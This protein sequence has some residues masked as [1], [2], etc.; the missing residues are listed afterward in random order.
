MID[1][2]FNQDIECVKCKNQ[3]NEPLFSYCNCG[4]NF[5]KT[6]EEEYFSSDSNFTSIHEVLSLLKDI[7]NYYGFEILK[8][9][10][11]SFLQ[12]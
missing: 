6:F 9:L 5:Q 3:K 7:S 8:N 1:F 2:Y 12:Y 4:G 11:E 10:I